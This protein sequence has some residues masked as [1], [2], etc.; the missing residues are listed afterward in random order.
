MDTSAANRGTFAALQKKIPYLRDQG[1][2][3]VE[4][5]PVYEFEE[6][7]QK[8]KDKLPDYVTWKKKAKEKMKERTI[9]I[10]SQ[11]IITGIRIQSL[12]SRDLILADFQS[13]CVNYMH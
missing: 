2:T 8:T 6:I 12:R 10:I 1:V 4:L 11:E 3:S 9:R 7:E 13:L 5:M